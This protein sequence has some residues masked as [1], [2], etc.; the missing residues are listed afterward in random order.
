MRLL[1]LSIPLLFLL[2]C[3]PA[4]V[5]KDAMPPEVEA[6]NTIPEQFHGVYMCESDSSRIY[7]ERDHAVQESYYQFVTSIERVRES[8]DCSIV[9]GGLYLPGRKECIPFEWI[10]EDSITAR[11]YELDTL[12]QFAD[13]EVVKYYKGHLFLNKLSDD[14]HWVTWM[15]TPQEDGSLLFELIE[16]PD[17][18]RKVQEITIDYETIQKDEETVQYVINPTLVEFDRILDKDYVR[19]CDILRPINFENSYFR[20]AY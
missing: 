8:E 6:I 2:A 7:I 1:L 12:M 20:K 13:D 10:N 11:V 19:E 15:L 14:N 18:K 17:N 9:A 5:F 4:V 3:E 16:V